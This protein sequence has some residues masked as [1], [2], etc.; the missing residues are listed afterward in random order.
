MSIVLDDGSSTIRSVLFGESIN[1]LG[2]TDEE[3]FSLEKFAEKRSYL[4]GEE[5]VFY[6]NAKN[7]VLY[8]NVEFNIENL[9]GIDLDNL[10]KEL[11]A[12][13]K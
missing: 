3:I 8:N 10:I 7:N 11:E 6:G 13:A 9:E 5:R 12:P 2:F 4:V 1:K